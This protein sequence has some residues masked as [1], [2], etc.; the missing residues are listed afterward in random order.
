VNTFLRAL[1]LY[2]NYISGF[3]MLPNHCKISGRIGE[4][5]GRREQ[6]V[7]Q[8]FRHGDRLLKLH[9]CQNLVQPLSGFFRENPKTFE[10]C[11]R[12]FWPV[13]GN[14]GYG[15]FTVVKEV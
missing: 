14:I 2:F 13:F 10:L 9:H 6:K 7:F 12:T 1:N 3:T 11:G 8:P 15:M 4:K 5:F